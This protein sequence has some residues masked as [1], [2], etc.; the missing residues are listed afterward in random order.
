MFTVIDAKFELRA[1]KVGDDPSN[2][3]KVQLDRH[4]E[5]E[6]VTKF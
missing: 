2:N 3:V 4:A 6:A 1:R 5:L